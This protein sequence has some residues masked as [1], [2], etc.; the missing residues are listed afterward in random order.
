MIDRSNEIRDM[1][2]ESR[3]WLQ[4]EYEKA[5]E[6]ERREKLENLKQWEA[7]QKGAK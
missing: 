1:S 2:L 6:K 7:E 5:T 4:A 3:K